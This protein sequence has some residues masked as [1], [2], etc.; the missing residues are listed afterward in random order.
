MYTALHCAE[1]L[2]VQGRRTTPNPY[3]PLAAPGILKASF[4]AN[5]DSVQC[6][7]FN[8]TAFQENNS[9][10]DILWPYNS[11][12]RW[13]KPRQHVPVAA[14][15]ALRMKDLHSLGRIVQACLFLP[16]RLL[17]SPTCQ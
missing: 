7:T 11:S 17:H 5:K 12:S 3:Q 10:L 13:G 6:A 16:F 8:L 14:S 1:A 2:Q 4:A 9:N 15:A